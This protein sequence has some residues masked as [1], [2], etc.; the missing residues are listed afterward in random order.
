MTGNENHDISLTDAAVLTKNYRT[1]PATT[2]VN[3]ITGIKAQAFGKDAI[4]E[5]LDQSGCVGIR[6][7]YGME[8]IPPSFKLIGVGVDAND[9]DMTSGK[10]IQHSLMCPTICSTSNVLNSDV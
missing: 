9:D 4:Q 5:I 8:L 7:Y 2:V 1:V 3:G 6:F 10:L